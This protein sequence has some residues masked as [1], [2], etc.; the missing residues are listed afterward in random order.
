MGGD[1]MKNKKVYLAKISYDSILGIYERE[2]DACDAVRT[3]NK[4]FY[5]NEAVYSNKEIIEAKAYN[6]CWVTAYD[7]NKAN[8]V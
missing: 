6:G 4:E 8:D 3:Y 5:E 1:K 7:L 2:Q